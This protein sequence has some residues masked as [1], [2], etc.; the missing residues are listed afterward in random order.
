M[1]LWLAFLL[2]LTVICHGKSANLPK[3]DSGCKEHNPRS[4]VDHLRNGANRS[5]YYKIYDAAG[6][7]FTVY[8][9]METEPGA[10]W[11]LVVSWSLENKDFS[12]F[13]SAPLSVND[14]VNENSPNWSLY[15]LTV[16]RMRSLKDESTHW[17]ATCSFDKHG[18]NHY[19][20]Y[21]RGRFAEADIFDFLG[22]GVCLKT[23]LVNIRGHMAIRKTA[24]FW[25]AANLH[26]LHIDSAAKGCQFDPTLGAVPSEDNFGFYDRINPKF[27]CTMNGNSTTQ[28]WFGG[29]Q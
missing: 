28:W 26:F 21:V 17:R 6:N 11:T 5:G 10:A 16:D 29:Y 25:Q 14:P 8:C 24:R 18:I 19:K 9:D 4:C 15:R 13:R 7:G 12:S 2:F 1:Q 20:D 22:G 27:T 3:N 23:E